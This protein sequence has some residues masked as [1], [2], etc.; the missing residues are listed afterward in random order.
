MPG[1]V[2][3]ERLTLDVSKTAKENLRELAAREDRSMGSMLDR[4]LCSK[5]NL[6][7][8]LSAT[9]LPPLSEKEAENA[10]VD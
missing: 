6:N 1:P 7:K 8:L 5:E 3:K 10:A 2:R 4:I 9:T